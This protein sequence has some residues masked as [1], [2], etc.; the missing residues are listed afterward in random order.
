MK[1][2]RIPVTAPV[3]AV[4]IPEVWLRDFRNTCEYALLIGPAVSSVHGV[5]DIGRF[6][7]GYKESLS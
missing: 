7:D 2:R 5:I 3:L 1:S 6:F 4:F